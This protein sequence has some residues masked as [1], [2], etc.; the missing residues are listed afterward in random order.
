MKMER[1]FMFRFETL[2]IWKESIDYCDR[3]YEI[4]DTFPS[5]VQYTLGSQL[6]GSALSVPNNIA[7]GS[8]S[9]SRLEFKN[10]LNYSIRSI[11]ETASALTL[12][13]RRQYISKEQFQELYQFSEKLVRR[14]SSFR[15]VV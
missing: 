12:A 11:F 15:H 1:G 3:I 14:I 9:S 10:F 13:C 6:R 5:N 7:E 2:D 4:V 8:G